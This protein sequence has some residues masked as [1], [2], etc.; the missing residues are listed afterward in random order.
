MTT[1]R[2]RSRAIADQLI[3]IS[4][5][6]QRDHLLARGLGLEHLREL[7][8]RVARPLV[9]QGASLAYGGFWKEVEENFT[10]D[11]LRLISAEQEDNSLGGPDTN[12]TIGRLIN[13]SAWP[14]YLEITPKIEAQWLNCCRIIRVTQEEAGIPAAETVPDAEAKSG[15]DRALLHGAI[16]LSTMRRL[17]MTGMSITVPDAGSETVPPAIARIVLGG[18][19]QGY[20]GFLPGIF[21]EA[22]LTLEHQR[23]LYVLGGFGGAAEILAKALLGSGEGC[24]AE[25]TSSWHEQRTPDVAKLATL[26]APFAL[27]SQVRPT[28]AALDAL[29]AFVKQ[30]RTDLPGVLRTGLSADETRELLTTRDITRTVQ[31]VRE[32]L[33]KQLGLQTL[34]A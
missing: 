30:A 22:S 7:L 24:P 9:R 2:H 4:I 17:I 3:A 19:M 5:A 18:K 25:L 23:P 20:R 10:F 31:L 27:P 15:S 32:G 1:R 8:L 33:E 13:H 34:P 29:S 26:T 6:Y 21:E 11:L 14:D 28:S 16:T 12:L